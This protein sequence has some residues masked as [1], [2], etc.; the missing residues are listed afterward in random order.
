MW[1]LTI[2]AVFVFY[3]ITLIRRGKNKLAHSKKWCGKFVVTCGLFANM[4]NNIVMRNRLDFSTKFSNL[5]ELTRSLPFIFSGQN[6]LCGHFTDFK[7]CLKF[8]SRFIQCAKKIR[9][10]VIFSFYCEFCLLLEITRPEIND[11]TSIDQFG[12]Y[13][14]KYLIT[15]SSLSSLTYLMTYNEKWNYE[16]F[17]IHIYL[18]GLTMRYF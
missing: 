3:S 10:T 5:P 1:R 2:N 8:I 12:Q 4:L 9:K 15:I 18:L 13:I 16:A 17:I 7:K 14:C 11:Y 6:F